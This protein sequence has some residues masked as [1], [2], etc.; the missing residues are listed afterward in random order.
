MK[1]LVLSG[2]PK[3]DKSVTLLYLRYIEKHAREHEFR[4]LH[5]G[6]E[7]GR[8]EKDK[9]YLGEILGSA[10]ECDAFIW[11][12]P[13][14][15]TLVPYQM[16][17]FIELILEHESRDAFKGKYATAL[18]TSIH[19]FDH[20]AH[21]YVRGICEDLGM[22]YIEGY[23][24][25]MQDLLIPESRGELRKFGRFFIQACQERWVTGRETSTLPPP[26]P[27]YEPGPVQEAPKREIGKVV[28]FSDARD[29][30]TSLRNMID[31]FVKKL[32]SPV[33]VV[34][35]NALDMKGGC[36]S[37]YRCAWNNECVYKDDFVETYKSKLIPAD[38]VI[39]GGSLRDRF[40]SSR[41]KMFMDR[42]FFNGH[43]PILGGKQL[44]YVLSG[45]LNQVPELREILEGMA[46]N[47]GA[48]LAGIITDEERD[49]ERLTGQI[50]GFVQKIIWMSR[51][52]MKKPSTFLGVGGHMIF[53][54]M[55]SMGG[56][57]FRADHLYYK[58]HGLYDY[59]WK[60]PRKK[61]QSTF[62]SLL[63]AFPGSREMLY[64]EAAQKMLE[65]FLKVIDEED[66]ERKGAH[67]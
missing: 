63:T 32:G 39:Y 50:E 61:L 26:S 30:D 8:L 65:P 17:R 34:D 5:L 44:G 28:L 7:I 27:P 23:S 2:S 51:E 45:P 11:C 48:S 38:I 29:E 67:S 57:F 62:M 56:W 64:K 58:H 52:K 24:A 12:F 55:I 40:L 43:R 3:G 15:V 10:R 53:R 49:A 6:K 21:R 66:V 41:W 35:I 16:K 25:D 20:V 54:D 22:E 19:F 4:V 14:Y 60:D 46:Q 1:I 47:G 37:C 31:V 59:P 33:E 18:T 9:E 13:I 36:L 42:S